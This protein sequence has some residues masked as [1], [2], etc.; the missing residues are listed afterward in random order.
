MILEGFLGINVI[1]IARAAF[2]RPK[3]SLGC[4]GDCF[5]LHLHLRAGA[6]VSLAMTEVSQQWNP[7]SYS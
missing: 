7:V 3:Q 6:S 4:V 2:F 5:G 1:V